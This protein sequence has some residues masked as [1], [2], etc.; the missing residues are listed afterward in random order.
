MSNGETN[1]VWAFQSPGDEREKKLLHESI[2]SGKSRFG[3]SF[4]DKHDLRLEDNWTDEHSKQLFL[5]QI[6][7][8]DW[9]VHINLPV[10]GRCVAAKVCS[11]YKFGE[12]LELPWREEWTRKDFRHCFEID[13]N[14]ITEFGRRDPEI[15]PSV[16]LSPRSRYHRIYAVVDFHQSIENLKNGKQEDHLKNKIKGHTLPEISR[17]IHEMNPGKN[18][19]GFLAKVFRK[20]PTVEWVR[21]NGSGRGTDFGADLI[22]KTSKSLGSLSYENTI[23]VQVKSYEGTH[24]DL[25]A[26]DQI[27]EGIKKFNGTAGIIITTAEKSE[28]LENKI[29]EASDE[30]GGIPID[31]MDAPD[32][33]RFVIKHAPKK[34]FDLDF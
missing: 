31:L 18:L 21:E 29:L 19:E 24:H 28:Q 3:W 11:E 22:V 27:K 23:I 9:I 17:Y 34:L 14:S 32:V 25:H 12:A 13:I 8:G 16:N 7:E 4:L 1:S 26:V 15:L 33:A 30:L 10:W 20:I 2:K 5:L 6:K